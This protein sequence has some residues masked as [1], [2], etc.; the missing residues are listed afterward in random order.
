MRSK[1]CARYLDNAAYVFVKIMGR[2]D[3]ACRVRAA[4]LIGWG[5]V[6]LIPSPSI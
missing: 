2:G 3:S 1:R 4:L 6:K 5:W